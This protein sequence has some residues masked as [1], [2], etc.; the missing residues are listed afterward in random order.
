Y[1]E[2]NVDLDLPLYRFDS[3]GFYTLLSITPLTGVL[4]FVRGI[5]HLGSTLYL[6]ARN[7]LFTVDAKNPRKPVIT[8]H[9][10]FD[11]TVT[12]DNVRHLTVS[13]S[14][15]LLFAACDSSRVLL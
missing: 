11:R 10:S 12:S 5:V 15:T 1:V 9:I 4:D 14:V 13:S 3:N 8:S 6:L 7:A 2:G